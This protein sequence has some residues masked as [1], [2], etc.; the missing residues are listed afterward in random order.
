M[1]DI[2]G[3]LRLAIATLLLCLLLAM[4]IAPW[5]GGPTGLESFAA[6]NEAL[7]GRYALAFEILAVLLLAA[8]IGA[9]LLARKEGPRP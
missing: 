7:F 8:L 3:L 9:L 1:N 6:I 2:R 4:L 5:P